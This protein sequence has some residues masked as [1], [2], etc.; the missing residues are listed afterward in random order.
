M[1]KGSPCFIFRAAHGPDDSTIRVAVGLRLDGQ[2]CVV[3]TLVSTV[4][5]K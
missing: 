2:C 1:A 3:H 4:R 5:W